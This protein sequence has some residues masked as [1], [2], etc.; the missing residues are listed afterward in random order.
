MSEQATTTSKRTRGAY[1]R[2]ICLGCHERRIKCE[3]PDDVVVPDLG[4]LRTIANP[5]YRCKKLGVDC[6]VRRTRLGR[7]GLGDAAT[8]SLA[9]GIPD[10]MRSVSSYAIDLP[11]GQGDYQVGWSDVVVPISQPDS[12]SPALPIPRCMNP[13]KVQILPLRRA[14]LPSR[15]EE[16]SS[17]SSDG[18]LITVKRTRASKPKVRTGCLT[19]KIRRVCSLLVGV[20]CLAYFSIRSN[21][22]R[23]NLRVLNA[24]VLDVSVMAIPH[25]RRLG[26]KMSL[27]LLDC[28]SQR[29]DWL[30]HH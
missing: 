5:C 22:T 19:C 2:L 20:F 4:E 29:G 9:A 28:Q 25:H 3:L 27:V 23:G 6:V 7:P 26:P 13:A 24:A 30:S 16:T 11:L 18:R 14:A 17:S 10:E 21:V 12:R 15:S 1:S 8:T